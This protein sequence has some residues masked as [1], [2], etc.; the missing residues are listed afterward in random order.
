MTG[1]GWRINNS[2]EWISNRLNSYRKQQ[3]ESSNTS[4]LDS[5]INTSNQNYFNS[6]VVWDQELS[7]QYNKASQLDA[8]AAIVKGK[9]I[10]KWEDWSKEITAKQ[11]LSRYYKE[12]NS[13][14]WANRLAEYANS[15]WNPYDFALSEWVVLSQ[16]E[17]KLNKRLNELKLVFWDWVPTWLAKTYWWTQDVLDAVWSP[18]DTIWNWLTEL[19]LS[20]KDNP[21][22]KVIW[23]IDNYAK[24]T[25][26]KEVRELDK[27]EMYKI[28]V[29]LQDDKTF[30]DMSPDTL[31]WLTEQLE[32][33][34]QAWVEFAYP[35]A[36]V[37]LG[38]ASQTKPWEVALSVIADYWLHP[39]WQLI[40][41]LVAPLEFW[42]MQLPT[43][44]DKEEF[45]KTVAWAFFLWAGNKNWNKSPAL[46]STI[47]DIKSFVKEVPILDIFYRNKSTKWW[48]WT[49]LEKTESWLKPIT[50]EEMNKIFEES[51]NNPKQEEIVD[52][53]S[54][55]KW[56]KM[57]GKQLDTVNKIRAWYG[58]KDNPMKT[59]NQMVNTITKWE[60]PWASSFE[61]AAQ[62]SL[63][64]EK[65]AVKEKDDM[66][67]K[68]TK[69]YGKEDVT[70]METN[71]FWE[72]VPSEPLIEAL[73]DLIADT[74]NAA[75]KSSYE[76]YKQKIA[77]WT[78]THSEIENIIT[79]YKQEYGASTF[80]INW[81]RK[82]WKTAKSAWELM[83]ELNEI[84]QKLADESGVEWLNSEFLKNQNQT[85]SDAIV[86][87][88]VFNILNNK[89]INLE[90]RISRWMPWWEYISFSIRQFLWK[91]LNKL[92]TSKIRNEIDVESSLNKW[93]KEI[94]K[95]EQK[96][97]WWA[98]FKDINKD[99]NK[100]YDTA[101]DA[102][103]DIIDSSFDNPSVSI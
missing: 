6:L 61:E 49:A 17:E 66:I 70:R 60:E 9:W 48:N 62:K 75:K 33:L 18:A 10:D 37:W 53:Q 93:T 97:D 74:R 2:V 89:V 42:R 63:D 34:F 51:K 81:E 90:S 103:D 57:R 40:N 68:N 20:D 39:V 80:K 44:E 7:R 88:K 84:S 15:D 16:D 24:R 67:K 21:E 77:D 69:L 99:L 56:K 11:V 32:W 27:Y 14:W 22:A 55:L 78:I 94:D 95:I 65:N 46:E 30:A 64:V 92:T 43:E 50:E 91:V 12:N 52:S 41:W 72:Q 26:G 45:D 13:D 31:R 35:Q 4:D 71:D 5:L 76:W 86:T 36:S 59:N 102:L 87:R 101:L 38:T 79:K 73:D 82:S 83:N 85:I 1:W 19:Y 58:N 47:Q 3:K 100:S 8:Y 28:L 54:E 98:S 29:D 25:F 96:I 23:A